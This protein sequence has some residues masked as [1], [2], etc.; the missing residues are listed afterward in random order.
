MPAGAATPSRSPRRLCIFSF[1]DNHGIV[2]DY[3]IHLL[4]ELGRHVQHILFYANGT[5]DEASRLAL[6]DLV[7]EVILRSDV[8]FDTMAYKEGLQRIDFNR[9]GSYDEV[10]MVNHTCYGPIYPF[11][12]LFDAMAARECDF[13]GVTAHMEMVPN[14]FLG[15]GRLPYHINTHFIAVRAPMLGSQAFRSYWES[16]SA[17]A[18]AADAVMGHEAIFTE[19]FTRRGFKGETYLDCRK[20]GTHDP[21]LLDIDETLV[22]RNP[23][24]RRQAFFHEPSLMEHYAVDLPSALAIIER[25]S[26]YDMSMIWRNAARA[27]PLRTLNTNAALTSVFPDVRLKAADASTDYGRIAVCAH[28]YYVDMVDELLTLAD[29]IPCT[30]DFIATTETEAKKQAIEAAAAGHKNIGQVIVRVVEQNRGRDISS[31]FIA[32]RDLFIDD[33]YDLVCRLHT[34][35]TP[36]LAAGR[37]AVFKR[38]MFDNLL[39]S[40]GYTTNVLDMFKDKPWVGMAVPTIIQMSYGTLGH[41]WGNNRARTEQVARQLGIEVP[42]D[43]STP[44]GAFGSMF[45]FRPKALRKLFAHPWQWTDFEAEPYPLDGSLGHAIERL[46]TYVAQ[47][48]RYTTQQI[49]CSPLAN[50]NFAMLEY[51]LQKL[52]SALPSPD[53]LAQTTLLD[54]WKRAGYQSD[55]EV[56]VLVQPSSISEAWGNLVQAL[57]RSIIFRAPR[58]AYAL[59][60]IH[61]SIVRTAKHPQG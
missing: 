1:Q 41:A 55:A 40:R 36:H 17:Q 27:A 60:R 45:W 37:S 43:E 51:K 12:E 30:Y 4:R 25:T 26:D 44:V 39:K 54:S 15:M 47:D 10:L 31:L 29:T 48:A 61:R 8:G 57:R 58:L 5:L 59:A 6:K 18:S 49:I 32:C 46:I 3:V 35:K 38:H 19:H 42:F 56:K 24:L 20:Y 14:P 9:D 11:A 23:L 13:W 7:Q 50:W 21:A 33:R 52:S 28:V 53:F 16:Q 34:K 22:D 2:D